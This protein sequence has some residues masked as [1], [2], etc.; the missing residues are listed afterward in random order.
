MNQSG[1]IN[2]R[3]KRTRGQSRRRDLLELSGIYALILIVIWTPRPW[4]FLL[5]GHRGNRHVLHR[6]PVV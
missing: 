1:L 3:T 2:D 5:L 6:I 4:Q